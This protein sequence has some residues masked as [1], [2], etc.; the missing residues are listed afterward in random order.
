M[1]RITII[2]ENETYLTPGACAHATKKVSGDSLVPESEERDSYSSVF[3]LSG[4]F[5]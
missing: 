5:E 1:P 2:V 3:S 4:C